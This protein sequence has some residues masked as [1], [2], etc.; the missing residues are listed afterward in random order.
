MKVLLF[1]FHFLYFNVFSQESFKFDNKSFEN[2][3]D[4]I[5]YSIGDGAMAGC[6]LTYN[7]YISKLKFLEE[8]FSNL[9]SLQTI[10]KTWN[11]NNITA[12]KIA[13]Q[14]RSNKGILFTGMHHGREPTSM[15]MNLYLIHKLVYLNTMYKN[16]TSISDL[17]N[18][19]NI[20]FIPIL[21]VDGYKANNE[22]FQIS[23]DINKCMIRKNRRV[24]PPEK[25]E[26]CIDNEDSDNITPGVDLNRNYG[27]KFAHDNEG[28]SSHPCNDDYRGEEAFS[29]PE[30][31]A[32]KAFVESHPD[33]KIA[34]NYHSWG[35]MYITPF[36][37]ADSAE[38][39]KKMF[40]N[41]TV[42]K[43]VYNDFFEEAQFPDH[44]VHGNGKETI[45]YRANG[46]A[47]DWMLG[48]K[49]IVA[50][51]PE[52]GIPN[53]N[54][55]RFYPNKDTVFEVM[56]Q[57]INSALYAIT[58]AAYYLQF[59]TL[60]K[61]YVDCNVVKLLTHKFL[62]KDEEEIFEEKLCENKF[63]QFS[64]QVELVNKGFSNFNG[65]TEFEIF[66]PF[67]K[68]INFISI[69]LKSGYTSLINLNMTENTIGLPDNDY[70]YFYNSS[71]SKNANNELKTNFKINYIESFNHVVLDVKVYIEKENYDK[72]GSK[73][74]PFISIRRFEEGKV[75][76]KNKNFLFTNYNLKFDI[77]EFQIMLSDF[78]YFNFKQD[79]KN[80]S[81]SNRSKYSIYVYLITAIF[82]GF[83]I[84]SIIVLYKLYKGRQDLTIINPHPTT[85]RQNYQ[86][87][88]NVQ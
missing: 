54:S 44:L 82:I 75:L 56:K 1:I 72:E 43:L 61:M 31:K 32:I 19:V 88:T 24:T 16:D 87:L 55:E 8:K 40:M 59:N 71:E 64:M 36:N 13:S 21:N 62:E 10:G 67:L 53:K 39:A 57:N 79:P 12:V 52:L 70:I 81:D 7:Q 77:P 58:R 63:Y 34:I 51:S 33:I 41:Y 37:Y 47:A 78:E 3:D 68:L 86:E 25:F 9:I 20:Y 2:F 74:S 22:I 18:S 38:S 6:C 14:F 85:G 76:D 5:Q 30:T 83:I 15:M 48:E 80:E 26:H 49:F 23:G 45:N 50:F 27:F 35:N 84:F 46:E 29:E 4:F 73:D 11:N 17:L 28:S 69:K 65:E 66:S 42:Q 60:K